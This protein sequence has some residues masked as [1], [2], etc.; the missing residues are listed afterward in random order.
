[1]NCPP[2]RGGIGRPQAI[3]H[4]IQPVLLTISARTLPGRRPPEAVP[5]VT[6]DFA[7]QLKELQRR[8]R[9]R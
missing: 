3:P 2:F 9:R 4:R 8:G 5:L 1:L 6:L 7:E